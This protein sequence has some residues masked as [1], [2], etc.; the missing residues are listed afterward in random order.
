[1]GLLMMVMNGGRELGKARA[2]AEMTSP[3]GFSGLPVDR[4]L[5]NGAERVSEAL[6]ALRD[7]SVVHPEPAL[8]PSKQPS[9]DRPRMT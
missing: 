8:L 5:A 7:K 3:A 6:H 1:M 9:L 2:G 4:T